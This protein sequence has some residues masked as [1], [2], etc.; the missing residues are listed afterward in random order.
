MNVS[1]TGHT[2]LPITILHFAGDSGADFDL[3]KLMQISLSCAERLL[4]SPH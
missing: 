1:R 4:I 3:E 2:K